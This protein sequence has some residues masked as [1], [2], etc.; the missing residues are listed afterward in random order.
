MTG[1]SSDDTFP[2]TVEHNDGQSLPSDEYD[3]DGLVDG[4]DSVNASADELREEQKSDDT[5]K[6]QLGVSFTR[7]WELFREGR[8]PLSQRDDLGT[9]LRTNVCPVNVV[10]K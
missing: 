7:M 10:S 5:Q 2:K 1:N 6:G 4:T 9:K 3:M 8:G